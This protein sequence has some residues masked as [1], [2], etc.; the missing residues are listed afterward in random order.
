VAVRLARNRSRSDQLQV[1]RDESG[2]D[3]LLAAT[4][5]FVAGF[6]V[7]V[8]VLVGTTNSGLAITFAGGA[9][10]GLIGGVLGY[11]TGWPLPS[12]KAV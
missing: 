1:S 10:V 3:R 4:G 2:S 11:R 7:T 12:R 6:L 9:L 5:W 8:A